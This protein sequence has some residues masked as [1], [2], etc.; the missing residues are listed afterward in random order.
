MKNKDTK[1]TRTVEEK[2]KSAES[3]DLG[4]LFEVAEWYALGKYSLDQNKALSN[5]YYS[6]IREKLSTARPYI[7]ELEVINFKG[8]KEVKGS[9]RLHPNINVFVGINGCGK[10]TLLDAIVKSASWLTNGIRTKGIGKKIDNH[11]INNNPK[12]NDCFIKTVFTVNDKTEFEL[13]LFKSKKS[14]RLSSELAELKIL[15]EMYR[16]YHDE[17]ESYSL[18]LFAHYSVSRSLEIKLESNSKEEISLSPK[19]DAYK[20][21]FDEHKKYKQLVEWLV[22]L[23]ALS[24]HDS[25][26]EKDY[27]KKISEFETI[28]RIY[29]SLPDEIKLHQQFGIDMQRDMSELRTEIQNLEVL[30]NDTDSVVVK[31][32]KEAIYKFMDI[33]N[34]RVEIDDDTISVLMDKSGTTISSDELS[35]G[36]KALFSIVSDISRRL[37]LL[38][39]GK[40]N[41]SLHG[42]GVVTI[43]EIDLHLHPKWQQDIVIKL[44]EVFPNIQF[45]LTTHSPQVLSTIPNYC[46]KALDNNENGILSVQEPRFSLGSESKMILEDIFLT[47]SRPDKVDEVQKLNRY[48]ELI[49]EDRWD[50]DEALELESEL[51]SWAGEHDPIMRQLKMDIRL[52]ERRRG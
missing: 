3:G 44:S 27:L 45:I 43:D 10:T 30:R 15:S 37:V 8:I 7:S 18:P 12:S 6:N 23:D 11:E 41:H 17:N 16:F 51:V 26:I 33:S 49:K 14:S 47:D 29:K 31:V 32:V 35:Q 19:L 50:T 22:Q 24:S 5:E 25:Q 42:A 21:C 9:L 38:N 48:K 20:H 4:C 1:K 52:R 2:I 46:I 40:G 36:E 39:P 34:I 28:D 13:M